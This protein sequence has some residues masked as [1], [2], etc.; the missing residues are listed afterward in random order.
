MTSLTDKRF[1]VLRDLGYEG[2]VNDMLLSWLQDNTDDDPKTLPDA[3]RSML[4]TRT[5]LPLGNY[6]RV[7][8]WYELLGNLG[9]EGQL[10]DREMKFWEDGGFPIVNP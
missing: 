4:L 3:W 7:D 9:Y 2:Q 10:N 5:G 1:E 8:Y 6:N